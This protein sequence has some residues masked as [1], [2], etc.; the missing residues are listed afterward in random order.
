[1]KKTAEEILND[2]KLLP[3]D[4][5]YSDERGRPAL[6]AGVMTA[7]SAR[8]CVKIADEYA[9]Q[10]REGIEQLIENCKLI[11]EN[12][13]EVTPLDDIDYHELIIVKNLYRRFISELEKLLKPEL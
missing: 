11:L 12:T 5:I 9:S 4:I 1:M 8:K 3:I 2:F 10:E 6:H 13:K 7:M